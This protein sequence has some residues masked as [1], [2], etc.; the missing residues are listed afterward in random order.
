[1]ARF[2]SWVDAEPR[3]IPAAGIAAVAVVVL[4]LV[5]V[6]ALTALALLLL[7]IV[8]AVSVGIYRIYGEAFG[9]AWQRPDAVP[10]SVPSPPVPTMDPN[11]VPRT[12]TAMLP[13]LAPF[14]GAVPV[15]PS[16]VASA[17]SSLLRCP[18]C[19]E[20][21][22]IGAAT[23]PYCGCRLDRDH[24]Q[25][26]TV[27]P[28]PQAWAQPPVVHPQ[29]L[30]YLPP[31]VTRSGTYGGAVLLVIAAAIMIIG[32]FLP[33][34]TGRSTYEGT[35]SLSGLQVFGGTDGTIVIGL[36]ALI[37]VLGLLAASDPRRSTPVRIIS[38]G[39]AALI[40]LIALHDFQSLQANAA[41]VNYQGALSY[42]QGYGTANASV[43]LGLYVVGFAVILTLIGVLASP[44]RR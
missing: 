27:A 42:L 31:T 7:G 30:P 38:L 40:G 39:A 13:P 36:G 8:V 10:T 2:E 23:C 35:V 19:A 25:P 28:P 12:T 20:D 26:V 9:L 24:S 15:A 22:E 32:A 4:I 44:P 43:A 14:S 11:P 17:A 21:V 18:D 29:P 37:G 33:W 34:I 5:G 1:M 41:S 16:I 6:P 3:V